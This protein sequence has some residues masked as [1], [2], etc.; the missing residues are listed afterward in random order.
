MKIGDEIMVHGFVDEIRQDTV[1]IRNAGGYFGTAASEV[2]P[3][4]VRCKKCRISAI[5]GDDEEGTHYMW[6]S[7]IGHEVNP[8]DFCS[9]G[10]RSS[11]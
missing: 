11:E 9:Y 1:I 4:I 6:C 8:D 10:E 3:A 5:E 7:W 2:M